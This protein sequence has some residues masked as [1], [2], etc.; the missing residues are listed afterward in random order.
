MPFFHSS[1]CVS[2]KLLQAHSLA[3]VQND[4]FT[5]IIELQARR[6]MANPTTHLNYLNWRVDTIRVLVHNLV[7]YFVISIRNVVVLSMDY[8]NSSCNVSSMPKTVLPCCWCT[9]NCM[10]DK[11][12]SVAL[13]TGINFPRPIFRSYINAFWSRKRPCSPCHSDDLLQS[14]LKKMFNSSKMCLSEGSMT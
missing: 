9:K 11:P 3:A 2:I 12:V 5:F 8:W 4:R 1:L 10:Q 13:E 14:S 7:I 6:G